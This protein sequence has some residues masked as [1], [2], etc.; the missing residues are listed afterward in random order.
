MSFSNS[1]LM[2]I[3]I[4]FAMY[5]LSKTACSVH[6]NPLVLSTRMDHFCYKELQ[7]HE[8]RRR[9]HGCEHLPGQLRFKIQE[10]SSRL[11]TAPYPFQAFQEMVDGTFISLDESLLLDRYHHQF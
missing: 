11:H 10:S 7:H 2:R 6:S 3:S 1:L 5:L 8:I 4:T 9:S